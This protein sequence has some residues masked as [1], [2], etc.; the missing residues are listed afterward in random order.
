MY[1]QINTVVSPMA[2]TVDS[3]FH[4]AL[5]EHSFDGILLT[6]PDG[7]ILQANPAICQ[8]LGR[9]AQEI[10]RIGR[11]GIVDT[12]DPR[13]TAA[14]IERA[15][16][17]SVTA[18]LTLIRGDGSRIPVEMSSALF[19]DEQGRPR[20]SMIIRDI[21]HRKTLEMEREQ[22]FR[23]FKLAEDPMCIADPFG[24]FVRVN[25]AMS[26]VTGYSE[27][28]LLSKPFLQFVVPEDREST[29]AEMKRQVEE[30][31]SLHFVNRYRC[32]SAE[33]VQF[34]WSAYFDRSDGFTYATARDITLQSETETTLRRNYELLDRIFDT[35]HF[36][37]VYLDR[38]F[39]FLR[40]N[41]A[42]GDACGYAPKFFVGKN[43]FA[44]Y[45][46]AENETIFRR[47]A[48]TGQP[49]TIYA[50]PFEFPDHPEWG[51]T[52]WDWTLYPLRD[53][54][55]QVEGLLFALLDV[56][57]QRRA[58][59]RLRINEASLRTAIKG[60]D[61][62]LFHQDQ[63]LCYTWMYSPQLGYASKQF[64]GKTDADILP[65]DCVSSVVAL[66]RRVL[67]SGIGQRAEM[68][69]ADANQT[70]F[71]D[72]I[73][74]PM[75]DADGCIVGVAGAT[76][77]VTER[78]HAERAQAQLAAIVES[79]NDAIFMRGLD[80]SILVWNAA[81]EHLFGWSAH[82]ILGHPM[83]RIVPSDHTGSILDSLDGTESDEALR[84][85]ETRHLRKDGTLIPTQT[86]VSPV[87]NAAQ[88]VIA[89][90][91]T[92]RDMR[93]LKHK[94]EALRKLSQRLRR[95]EEAER[96]AIARELHD[97]IGQDLSTVG[98]LL[99]S[100]CAKLP[101][102]SQDL[103]SKP[104]NDIQNLLKSMVSNVRDIM[105]ELRPPVL[106]DYGLLAALRQLASDFSLRTGI[107]AELN[108][109]ELRPRL[110]TVVETTMFRI[111]QEVLN[112]VAKH[113]H[114]SHVVIDLCTGNHQVSLEIVDNGIGFDPAQ[115]PATQPHWGMTTM[116]E[117]AEEAGIRF[118]LASRP[119][120][121][122]RVVLQAERA[123]E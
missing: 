108:G 16:R 13:L 70:R 55:G 102:A 51:V 123:T 37:L 80:G 77:D 118:A 74:D 66:K 114:A 3:E 76:L 4:H 38:D 42:Y 90:S 97:R 1:F 121:G 28:E 67:E 120:A 35:T 109:F 79:S 98:L 64:V 46:N 45:P 105:A 32:K 36:C 43:H 68:P 47:A 110:P 73:V 26:R 12:E 60:V 117:R 7:Q 57:H 81:A 39:N 33:V 111:S 69:I 83:D 106:E 52:Y 65:L 61:M 101:P 53:A 19:N 30:R 122:T 58:E 88:Q 85:I 34:A 82:D 24:C 40:V 96:R 21:S 17:G 103:V 44:L 27:T 119:G 84:S 87:K 49:Y 50:K 95:V 59:E 63:N 10:R 112:N 23:F 86:T 14:L 25:P 41:K 62:T 6:A 48:L 89:Y 78:I 72:L 2:Q 94:E 29:A 92:V 54:Q 115:M 56:T 22:Y 100:V 20:S 11:A 93:A 31:P 9:S 5:F 18:E 113:A 71:I 99:G 116:R 107:A 104:L 15:R 8:M 75:M 91:Y